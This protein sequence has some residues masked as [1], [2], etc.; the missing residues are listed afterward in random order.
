MP[1]MAV[2]ENHR[3]GAITDWRVR[4]RY[5]GTRF[6]DALCDTNDSRGGGLKYGLIGVVADA[7]VV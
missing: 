4:S 6:T 7:K 3:H 1:C 5:G 2:V